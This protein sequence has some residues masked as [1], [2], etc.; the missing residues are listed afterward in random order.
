MQHRLVL[1]YTL[2]AGRL[3]P[4]IDGLRAGQAVA[5]SCG[6]CGQASFPP[7]RRCSCGATAGDWVTL[8]GTGTIVQCTDGPQVSFALV[9][10]DGA[11]ALSTVRLQQPARRGDRGHLVAVP[12]GSPAQV[13]AVASK[14]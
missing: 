8:P 5:L 4:W 7:R 12:D 6:A 11:A 14:E 9:K 10:F 2:S 3:Q 13:F 1:D